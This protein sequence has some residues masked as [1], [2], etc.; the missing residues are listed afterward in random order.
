MDQGSQNFRHDV[1]QKL[2][3]L[4]YGLCSVTDKPQTIILDPI[5]ASDVFNPEVIRTLAEW[6]EKVQP[7]FPSQFKVTFEGTQVWLENQV[8]KLFDRIL[9]FVKEVNVRDNVPIGHVGLYRF[10]WE[11]R[12]CEIDNIVRGRDSLFPG[13]MTLAVE[14]L[15][16]WSFNELG[17]KILYLKVLADNKKAIKLYERCGFKEHKLIPLRREEKLNMV[18]WEE[19]LTLK[20]AER[21][22]LQMRLD[23]PNL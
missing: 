11:E 13:A 8:I 21:Y 20:K 5:T 22:F 19:D 3:K 18:Q 16:N 7:Y 10:N 15:D 14:S 17:V 6:R 23:A 4:K 12:S 2:A 9:F 1:I